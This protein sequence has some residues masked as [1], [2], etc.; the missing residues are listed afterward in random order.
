[1]FLNGTAG[2]GWHFEQCLCFGL[3]I[4]NKY[5]FK[6]LGLNCR[7]LFEL[8]DDVQPGQLNPYY[9]LNN[10]TANSE[11]SNGRLAMIGVF[12]YMLQEFTTNQ[13]VLF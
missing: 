11:L 5:L 1:M 7:R 9:T 6:I 13:K 2:R 3:P 10:K 4:G 12:L 8:K